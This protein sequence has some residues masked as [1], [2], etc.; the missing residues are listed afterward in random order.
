VH[1]VAGWAVIHGGRQRTRTVAWL[2]VRNADLGEDVDPVALAHRRLQERG[3]GEAVGLLTSRRIDRF[4]E[5][6]VAHD[7][8]HARS[9]ATV[10]LSNALRVGDPPGPLRIGIAPGAPG[11][12]TINVLVAVSARLSEA[13]AWEA[14]S[15]ATE[16]RTAAVMAAGFPSRRTG[17]VATGTGT[18]CIVLAWPAGHGENEGKSGGDVDVDGGAH[19]VAFAGKHTPLG[20][21]IGE[22]VF[23]AVRAGVA[24][25]LDEYQLGGTR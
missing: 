8:L 9:L 16:A 13:A 4:H 7:G 10:G 21:A 12:G 6:A 1:E 15:I 23:E 18:D 5:A 14:M 19:A 22:S 3:L 17:A 2:E 24:A 25:W 20:H 11:Y